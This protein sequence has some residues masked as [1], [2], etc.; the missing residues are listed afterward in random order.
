MEVVR[1]PLLPRACTHARGHLLQNA[2]AT[3]PGRARLSRARP[4]YQWD[5]LAGSRSGHRLLASADSIF[6]RYRS[7]ANRPLFDRES[8]CQEFSEASTFVRL[9]GQMTTAS[10]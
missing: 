3:L 1:R 6:Y 8:N 5:R 2:L 4:A 10:G 7:G 9:Q